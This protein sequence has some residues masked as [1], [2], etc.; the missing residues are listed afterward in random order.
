MTTRHTNPAWTLIAIFLA[1]V[2]VPRIHAQG[3]LVDQVIAVVSQPPHL[4]DLL[5]EAG[6][7]QARALAQRQP[8]DGQRVNRVGLAP[9]PPAAPLPGHQLR[10]HEHDLLPGRQ[11]L[12]DQPAGHVP[13]VEQPEAFV[14]AA[15][16][17]LDGEG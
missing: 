15:L 4:Q 10:R 9:L 12:P 11:Q 17:F 16:A 5:I 14:K 7:G 6:S 8:R 13:H 2:A 3:V 1:L